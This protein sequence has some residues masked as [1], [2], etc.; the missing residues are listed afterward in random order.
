MLNG[1]LSKWRFVPNFQF[2][3]ARAR[4]VRQIS[5][6]VCALSWHLSL[7]RTWRIFG[8]RATHVLHLCSWLHARDGRRFLCKKAFHTQSSRHSEQRKTTLLC[9]TKLFQPV[10]PHS[11]QLVVVINNNHEASSCSFRPYRIRCGLCPF[12]Q[13]CY[14]HVVSSKRW[15][16]EVAC[17]RLSIILRMRL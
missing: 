13:V 10:I 11:F 4:R 14:Q 3:C 5:T 12:H 16:H 1:V 8:L 6:E 2:T 9:S 17:C 7:W 15:Y